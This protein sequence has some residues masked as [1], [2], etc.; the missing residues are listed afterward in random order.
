MHISFRLLKPL[1]SPLRTN[2]Q[3]IALSILYVLLARRLLHEKKE[4]KKAIKVVYVVVVKE[5]EFFLTSFS[6]SLMSSL[7]RQSPKWDFLPKIKTPKRKK[8]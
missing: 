3:R 2:R 6:S 1:L 7:S 8:E 4:N 5:E